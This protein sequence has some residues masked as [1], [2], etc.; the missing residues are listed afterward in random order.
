[1][2]P[3]PLQ[4]RIRSRG[5]LVLG[6]LLCSGCDKEPVDCVALCERAHACRSEIGKSLVAR[7]PAQSPALLH[8][9][10]E[11]P[12]RLL[13]RVLGSCR[14]RCDRLSRSRKWRQALAPCR[15]VQ[16]CPEYASCVAPLLEP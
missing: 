4:R 12:G 16:A 15:P 2:G 7:L 11:L 13:D 14:E 8:V 1:M 9:R 6:V 5:I 3:S 10:R